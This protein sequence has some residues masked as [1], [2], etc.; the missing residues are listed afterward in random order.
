MDQDWRHGGPTDITNL[1]LACGCD[2]RLAD[3]S[4]WTTTMGPD[5]R[6]HWTPPPLLDIGQPR[7][8]EYHH[9]TLYPTE[10]ES[11]DETDSP[12]TYPKDGCTHYPLL[13][14]AVANPLMVSRMP[15]CT[16]SSS[17]PDR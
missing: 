6:T 17:S 15:R 11:D 9:P 16:S 14:S 2:N 4:G 12:T 5:G 1:T 7:T 3:T 13:R 8:N 10:S